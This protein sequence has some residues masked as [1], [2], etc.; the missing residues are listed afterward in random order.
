MTESLHSWTLPSVNAPMPQ[1]P[2]ARQVIAFT[3]LGEPA[4]KSNSR[5][6]ATIGA[7]TAIVDGERKRVGGRSMLIK[8]EKARS[9]VQAAY[10]QIPV[11]ARQMLEGPIRMTLRIFYCNERSDLD[12]QLI[13][14]VLQAQYK[15]EPGKLI[16][17]RTG[18]YAQEKSTR[19]LVR[20]GVYINDR[21]IKERHVFHFLDKFN[22]RTELEI[23][24]MMPQQSSLIDD[25]KPLRQRR[26]EI[27]ELPAKP[28]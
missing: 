3:I 9:Y 17:I 12:E 2:A 20:R 1:I 28:F 25:A 8:S 19:V 6:I 14:D 10:P 5:K 22:P 15:R 4:S 16:K 26:P 7:T 23:E 27:T 21:Q 11:E 13:L 18:E 24:A